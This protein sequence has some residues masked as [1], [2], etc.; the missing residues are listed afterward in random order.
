MNVFLPKFLIQTLRK[1]AKRKLGSRECGRGRITAQGC[2]SAGEEE[3]AAFTPPLTIVDR[4]ALEGGDRLARERKG[5]LDVRVRHLVDFVLG[6]LQKG[7]PYAET[8]VVERY[9]DV[10]GRPVCAHGAESVLDFFV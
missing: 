1:R 6:D 4:L 10:R 3:R 7:L 2:G 8:C 9:A 5:G